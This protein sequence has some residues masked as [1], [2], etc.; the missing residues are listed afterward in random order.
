LDYN[1]THGHEDRG[2][3]TAKQRRAISA[4]GHAHAAMHRRGTCIVMAR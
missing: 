2:H 1:A 3:C 4:E